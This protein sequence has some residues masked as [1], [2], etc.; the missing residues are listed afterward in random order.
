MKLANVQETGVS[1]L[2]VGRIFVR[3]FI[4]AWSGGCHCYTKSADI[5]ISFLTIHSMWLI[6]KRQKTDMCRN[7]H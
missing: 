7:I 6:M 4:L 2:G 1:V 5:I 3:P